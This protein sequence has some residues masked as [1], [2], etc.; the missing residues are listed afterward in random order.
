MA[1]TGDAASV[2]RYAVGLAAMER[3][4]DSFRRWRRRLLLDRHPS[5]VRVRLNLAACLPKTGRMDQ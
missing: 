4:A 3:Y 1:A 2:E 5:A